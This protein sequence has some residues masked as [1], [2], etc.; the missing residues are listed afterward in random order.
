M[1]LGYLYR[2]QKNFFT[3]WKLKKRCGIVYKVIKKYFDNSGVKILDVG[4]CDGKML[5]YI[6]DRI[7]SAECY[8]IEPIEEF[9]KANTDTRISLHI[10]C[11]EKI[12]FFDNSF[13]LVILSSVLEHIRDPQKCLIEVARVLKPKGKLVLL[14]VIPWYERLVVK[15]G[16]K[17]DDHFQNFTLPQLNE[18]V[19]KFGFKILEA[20]KMK[21]PL[22]YQLTVAEKNG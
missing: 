13:D 9:V 8:G 16:I 5:S 14:T 11:A 12:D 21:F 20:K 18:M 3:R 2:R 10:G 7:P 6:K 15:L 17:K 19:K 1:D 22:F 4:A